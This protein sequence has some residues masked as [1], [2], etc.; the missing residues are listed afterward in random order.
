MTELRVGSRVVIVAIALALLGGVAIGFW[1][2][3]IAF[4]VQ[5][6]NVDASDLKPSA[7][8]DFIALVASAYASDQD[9]A[10]AKDR[11]AQIK[12]SKIN[13][14]VAALSKKFAAQNNPEAGSIAALA[15]ALGNRDQTIALIA[16]TATPTPTETQTPT[17]TL[18]PTQTPTATP[19]L[20]PTMTI[21]PARRP[22]ARP[23]YTPTAKPAPIAPTTWVPG[24]PDGWPSFA[25]FES[26]SVAPGQKYW[27]LAKATY[28]DTNDEHD[29]CQNLPGGGIGTDTYV[30]LI[31][32][33][34]ERASAPIS[35]IGLDNK[36]VD[37]QEKS[38]SDMCNCNYSWQSNAATVQILGAPSDKISGLGLFS[39]KA[40]LRNFHVRYFLTF[41]LVT[42]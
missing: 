30:M 37:M 26:A 4:P 14:R 31:G 25:K 9:L 18:T 10:R 27:H 24:F 33:G 20:T 28:C 17:L 34:G 13:D 1:L 8:D 32:A 39:V 38:A 36:V 23:A 15:V 40:N 2:G 11:L 41:Q 5:V 21:T 42:R 12:D 6:A 19:S 35:V 22:T 29:Y 16:K 7:Q 3:W